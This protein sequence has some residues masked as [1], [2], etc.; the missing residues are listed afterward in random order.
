MISSKKI[1]LIGILLITVVFALTLYAVLFPSGFT[2]EASVGEVIFS[3]EHSVLMSEDDYYTSYTGHGTVKLELRGNTA[4]TSSRKVTVNGGDITISGGGAYI[5]SGTLTSGSITV[6]SSDGIPVRLI[7]GGVSVTSENGSALVIKNAD[8][9]VL[10]LVDGTENTF[11]DGEAYNAYKDTENAPTAAIYSRDDLT[12]NGKGTLKVNGRAY[13]GI[14]VNDTL[15]IT[16]GTVIVDAKD[17]GINVND[18]IYILGSSISISSVSDAVRCES[19]TPENS[20]I[21]LDGTTLSLVSAQGDGISCSGAIYSDGAVADVKTGGGSEAVQLSSGGF[22]GG[23]GGFGG[24]GGNAGSDGSST[25]AIK[26]GT[27]LRINGGEYKLDGKD[28]TVH[29]DGDIEITGGNFTLSSGNDAIHAD[30]TLLLSPESIDIT[31][32]LEGIEAGF[33]TIENGNISIVSSDDAINAVGTGSGGFGMPMGN[34]TQPVSEEKVYL[35]IKGGSI[36]A[37]TGGDGVDSN[38]AARISG[39]TVYVFGPENGGNG[40]LDFQ[41]GLL[42]DGG[43][44]LAAGSSGMAELPHRDSLQT[45]LSFYLSESFNAGSTIDIKD[46]DGNIVIGGISSKRFNW[47]CASTPTLRESESYTL[48]VNDKERSTLTVDSNV[49]SNR[50]NSTRR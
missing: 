46:E 35:T 12:I 48:F 20:F 42:I 49:T 6:D 40:S 7:L 3:E 1:T 39:G 26:A 29:S 9:T 18:G 41:D 36:Y 33:I 43:N 13:D 50:A 14:K 19:D 4:T 37:E 15:R 47:V 17:E 5:V 27:L 44:L 2:N 38:G 28:D 16:D 34:S 25:K 32:C 45:S 10:S 22:G 30:K 21:A 8:K 23:R 31:K 24:A 11:T